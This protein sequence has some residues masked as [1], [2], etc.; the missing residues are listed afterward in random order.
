[1]GGSDFISPRLCGL[2]AGALLALS[3]CTFLF[4]P[5]K[6]SQNSDGGSPPGNVDGGGGGGDG[7]VPPI[8]A[9][10][11]DARYIPPG[12]FGLTRLEPTTIFEGEGAAWPVPIVVH[13]QNIAPDATITLDGA[14]FTATEV[15]GTVASDGSMIVFPL[16]VPVLPTLA[17]GQSQAITITVQQ[18]GE[19]SELPLVVNG[20]DELLAS[21][22]PGNPSNVE[23]SELDPPYSSIVFD[24]NLTFTGTA[25]IR[26]VATAE[27]QLAATLS[28]S[29][30]SANKTTAGLGGPGGCAGGALSTD[31]QCDAGGG[32]AASNDEAAGGGGHFTIGTPGGGVPRGPGGQSTGRPEM[33]PLVDEHGNGGGGSATGAGGGGGGILELTSQGTFTITATGNLKADGGRGGEGICSASVSAGSG[34]GGSG[35]AILVRSFG[36]F[37]DQDTTPRL[38]VRGGDGGDMPPNR[39][40]QETGGAGSSGRMRVDTSELGGLEPFARATPTPFQGPLF[41]NRSANG[42]PIPVVVDLSQLTLDLVGQP[43][44]V[45]HVEVNGGARQPVNMSAGG[46]GSFTAQLQTGA[47]RICV[48][49]DEDT[50]IDLSEGAQCIVIA[51]IP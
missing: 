39:N 4:D 31:G 1:M 51:S 2:A 37:D 30:V 45:V 41:R 13:G 6:L 28:A 17:K 3:S 50:P 19:S 22:L 25:P 36:G 16:T 43:G 5:D 24:R 44:R 23:A 42:T 29:G 21:A 46:T 20:L 14:S 49:M 7:S 33:A 10:P 18:N 34:G 32:G 35:G 9:I 12:E 48:F 40:C 11:P 15:T 27:I 47:N 26:L 8:D 38:S